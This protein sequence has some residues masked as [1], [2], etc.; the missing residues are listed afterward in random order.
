M[1]EQEQQERHD[2]AVEANRELLHDVLH[3]DEL[4]NAWSIVR[5]Y[6]RLSGSGWD[7]LQRDLTSLDIDAADMP[8]RCCYRASDNLEEIKQITD[9]PAGGVG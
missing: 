1:L 4:N 3:T 2:E 6:W 9:I 7:E 8:E 5:G